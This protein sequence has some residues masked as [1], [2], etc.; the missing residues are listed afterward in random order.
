MK[1]LVYAVKLNTCAEL[2]N[3]IRDTSM[4]IRND[5]ISLMRSDASLS[6]RVTMCLDNQ[7][8]HLEQLPYV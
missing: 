1:S 8:S 4:Q 5:K 6:Q 3:H 2:L 7:E